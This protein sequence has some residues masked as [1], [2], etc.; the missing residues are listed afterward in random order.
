V[1]RVGSGLEVAARADDGVIEALEQG[2]RDF[3]IALQWHPEIHS[4]EDA[5]SLAVFSA[6][7]EAADE[8]RSRRR[9]SE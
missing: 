4:L 7:V 2:D 6:L 1:D 3:V 5:D 9:V 8:Y